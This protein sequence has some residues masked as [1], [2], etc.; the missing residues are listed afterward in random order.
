MLGVAMGLT[1]VGAARTA[2]PH[3]QEHRDRP[4]E[5]LR[6]APGPGHTG[7]GPAAHRSGGLAGRRLHAAGRR[8][9]RGVDVGA[10]DS[11]DRGPRTGHRLLAQRHGRRG[12]Q[13]GRPVAAPRGTARHGPQG[14]HPVRLRGPGARPALRAVAAQPDHD[15]GR[16]LD[17][18]GHHHPDLDHPDPAAAR[19][20][21][22]GPG[23]GG[24]RTRRRR[25]ADPH[26]HR[27]VHRHPRPGRRRPR[28]GRGPGRGRVH[29]AGRGGAAYRDDDR[30]H[31]RLLLDDRR[32]PARRLP[33]VRFGAR[34]LRR[35][36]LAEDRRPHRRRPAPRA[37]A[38]QPR[39]ARARPVH[40]LDGDPAGDP[41]RGPDRR[42]VA[43][44]DPARR[45]VSGARRDPHGPCPG[46]PRRPQE[47]RVRLPGQS[48]PLRRK[49]RW[50]A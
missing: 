34:R 23:V 9:R 16:H 8:R 40:H 50:M 30:V 15:L 24:H 42:A 1:L 46:D 12:A 39:R 29:A 14:A 11:R 7:R 18:P 5:H 32:R 26:R 47:A 28:P 13:P 2:V 6:R 27:H 41:G 49:P 48:Q 21:P 10:A 31:L 22:A 44:P 3:P 17:R 38:A 25:R 36:E 20:P 19:T 43:R 45:R 33:G 37:L 35:E 4:A